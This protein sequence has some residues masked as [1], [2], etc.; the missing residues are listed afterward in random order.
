MCQQES[1]QKKSIQF[2]TQFTHINL[3]LMNRI[4][5]NSQNKFYVYDQ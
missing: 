4:N 3:M 2:N 5:N 1:T